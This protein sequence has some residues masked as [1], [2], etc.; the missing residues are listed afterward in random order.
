MSG[1]C[2]DNETPAPG[3]EGGFG[4]ERK[5][6]GLKNGPDEVRDDQETETPS[7]DA[8]RANESDDDGSEIKVTDRRHWAREDDEEDGDGTVS[9]QPTIIDEYRQR[10]ETAE[11]RLQDY[12]AAY[13]KSQ[14]DMD[15]VRARL[16]R[17]LDDKVALRYG[18]LVGDLLG[19]LDDLDLSLGH[20]REVP[21][22]GA[23]AEGVTLVRDRFLATLERNGVERVDP[24]GED[25]DPNVAE[26]L[27]VDPV[28]DPD[29]D[30]KVTVVLRPGYRL[31]E[32][33]LRAAQVAVGRLNN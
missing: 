22:A 12:I 19:T 24:T 18:E 21:E 9:T 25:F 29:L 4:E 32:R 11:Q 15:G 28:D 27:R 3:D 7:A 20:I 30:G 31:G 5:V 6:T 1:G 8:G 2:W 26:A 16:A 33:M 17:D 10:A 14:A 23:L 13:K